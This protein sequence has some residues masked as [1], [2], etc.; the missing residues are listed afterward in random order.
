[1]AKEQPSSEAG[2]KGKAHT[3]RADALFKRTLRN[4]RRWIRA[5][6][7]GH[8]A[9]GRRMRRRS[10]RLTRKTMRAVK[11]ARRH[12]RRAGVKLKPAY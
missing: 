8:M 3:R 7:R 5:F 11:T 6:T 2:R 4:D 12:F 1:M 9:R 10:G